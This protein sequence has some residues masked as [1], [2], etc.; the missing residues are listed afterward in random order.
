R[1]HTNGKARDACPAQ[2]QKV[3]PQNIVRVG[4]QRYFCAVLDAEGSICCGEDR[5]DLLR[6]Q[7]RGRAA[8][9]INRI[10]LAML[11]QLAAVGAD[12]IGNGRDQ[13]IAGAVLGG[14]DVEVAIRADPRAVWPMHIEAKPEMRAEG[15]KNLGHASSA[16]RSFSTARAL[17]L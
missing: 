9:E 6:R 11:G 16:A 1:L 4:F 2:A 7:K 15:R 13:R 17:W 12:I 14:I 3:R 8:A 10:K 5:G